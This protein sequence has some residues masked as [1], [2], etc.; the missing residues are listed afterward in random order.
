VLLTDA[1][2]SL[3]F[4]TDKAPSEFAEQLSAAGYHVLEAMDISEVLHLCEQTQ[5]DAV[6]IAPQCADNV[7]LPIKLKQPAIQLGAEA[8]VAELVWELER[9]FP[10]KTSVIQ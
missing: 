7:W 9:L 10:R 5:V 4:L 8:S 2:T 3:V 1:V 6:V